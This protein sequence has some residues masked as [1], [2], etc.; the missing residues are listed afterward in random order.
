MQIND[1]TN[2][3]R[4]TTRNMILSYRV[5]TYLLTRRTYNYYVASTIHLKFFKKQI[6]HIE[7]VVNTVCIFKNILITELRTYRLQL[8]F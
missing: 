3:A 6:L 4:R 5:I 1:E 2:L 7:S 8:V